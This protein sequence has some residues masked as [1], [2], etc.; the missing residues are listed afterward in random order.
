MWQDEMITELKAAR[1]GERLKVMERYSAM[2][3][4]SIQNLYNIAAQGGYESGRKTRV[5][6]GKC[7]LNDSQ[8]SFISAQIHTTGRELKGPIMPVEL[9]LINAEDNGIIDPG[10]VSVSRLQEIL[11]DR[12]MNAAALKTPEPHIR[13]RSLHPNHV[14]VLDSSVCI[15]YYLKGKN[16]GFGI[17][18]ED[19]FYKNKY[20]NFNKVKKKLMRYVLVDHFS[21]TIFVK[22]Y[23]SG[24]E[25]QAN[26]YDFLLSAWGGDKHEKFPF[27]GVPFF[28]LM[29]AGAANTSGA[30]LEFLKRLDVQIPASLPHNPRRQGSAEVTQN[31]VEKW[32][33]SNLRIQPAHDVETLNAWALDWAVGFNGSRKHS[34]HGMT[35]TECWLK[36]KK[37]ELRELPEKEMLHYIYANPSAERTVRG[38]YTIGFSYKNNASGEYSVK[39]IP[40]LIPHR[41]KVDVIVR[42]H[43]WPEIGVVFNGVEYLVKPLGKVAGGFREDA[44]II[45]QEFKAMPESLPQQS[46]KMSDNLAYGED[47][48]RDAAPFEGLTVFG[49]YAE[50]VQRTFI[51]KAGT[52]EWGAGSSLAGPIHMEIPVTEFMKKVIRALGT[53]SRADNSLIR[54]RFGTSISL[55]ESERII[56]AVQAGAQLSDE[57]MTG[58]ENDTAQAASGGLRD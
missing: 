13:M 43:H 40:G 32:F 37:E 31:I 17:M 5:D 41:S 23:Y 44:A 2:T 10:A 21:H 47:R 22:Y 18:R 36:I 1:N 19:M 49:N 33:E 55:M 26:L 30:I 57:V 54:E 16:K 15:Q 56:A 7:E 3:G 46:K 51:P 52:S 11:R 39:H 34:R 58:G 24:G 50:K 6:K 53:I 12:G 45:G 35:R 48:K 14:H 20:T 28:V 4:K 8:V 38:D 25:T 9:A 27:R 29:D 42:P